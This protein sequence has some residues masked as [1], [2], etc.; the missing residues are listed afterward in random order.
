[1]DTFLDNLS[2]VLPALGVN[3]LTPVVKISSQLN[4]QL[5]T[6]IDEAIEA[7]FLF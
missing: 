2:F 6:T 4:T 5:A 1:M 7:E 3:L